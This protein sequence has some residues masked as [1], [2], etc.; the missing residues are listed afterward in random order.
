MQA[1][2][3]AMTSDGF[4]HFEQAEKELLAAYVFALSS[5][6]IITFFVLC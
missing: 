6:D 4:H 1:K 5:L 3:E 2:G